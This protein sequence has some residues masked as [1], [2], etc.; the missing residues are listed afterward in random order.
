[1]LDKI[2]E[3][4]PH[5]YKRGNLLPGDIVLE[6]FFVVCEG[7]NH[8]SQN[9]LYNIKLYISSLSKFQ[10]TGYKTCTA[11]NFDTQLIDRS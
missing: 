6:T 10:T 7:H 5:F 2:I 9:H 8:Q 3:I 11:G 1:M 4:N